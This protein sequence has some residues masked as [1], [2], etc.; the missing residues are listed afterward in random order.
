MGKKFYSLCLSISPCSISIMELIPQC[1][2]S[3]TLHLTLSDTALSFNF[4]Q[5]SLVWTSDT[6]VHFTI[7]LMWPRWLWRLLTALTQGDGRRVSS[8]KKTTPY[9]YDKL[10][11]PNNDDYTKNNKNKKM[12]FSLVLYKHLTNSTKLTVPQA[13]LSLDIPYRL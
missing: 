13:S 1:L 11:W 8:M 5:G 12:I 9:C 3:N 6:R 4:L 10:T 7:M 2:Q